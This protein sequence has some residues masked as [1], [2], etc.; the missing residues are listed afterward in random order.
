MERWHSSMKMVSKY[1]MGRRAANRAG[2]GCISGIGDAP[3]LGW[4][5]PS[6]L[7]RR[8]W[9]CRQ[10][11]GETG[12]QR[13][14]AHSDAA[15]GVEVHALVILNLPAG[16]L[17][18]PVDLYSRLLFRGIGWCHCTLSRLRGASSVAPGFSRDGRRT[19]NDEGRKFALVVRRS[20]FVPP[21][22]ILGTSVR[23]K[24]VNPIVNHSCQSYHI[25][26][27]LSIPHWNRLVYR[28]VN[29]PI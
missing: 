19:T 6:W 10:V 23:G 7:R 14:L 28:G 11:V 22:P 12:L 5:P 25:S 21:I 29:A 20:S 13:K 16:G 2:P 27:G 9:P 3:R 17:E 4:C 15:L 1:S 24:S 26:T 8:R 18:L